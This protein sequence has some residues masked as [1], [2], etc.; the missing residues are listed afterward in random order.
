MRKNARE[1]LR[2]RVNLGK[3][4]S[5]RR[6]ARASSCDGGCFARSHVQ[7]V[8]ADEVREARVGDSAAPAHAQRVDA[9]EVR[10]ARVGDPGAPPHSQR[11]DAG[12][13]REG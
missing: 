6:K 2:G 12:E 5:R 1:N 8:D 3:D 10:E 11:V 4:F 13:V 9:G 7:R